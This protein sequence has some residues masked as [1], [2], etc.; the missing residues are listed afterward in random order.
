MWID[1][2]SKDG[3]GHDVE[4]DPIA[5]GLLYLAVVQECVPLSPIFDKQQ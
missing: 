4:V 3:G 1:I 5:L 2:R